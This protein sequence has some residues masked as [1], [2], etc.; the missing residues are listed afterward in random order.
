MNNDYIDD[1][2]KACFYESYTM[3]EKL[4]VNTRRLLY[5]KQERKSSLLLCIIQVLMF[6]LS[7][8]MLLAAF[9]LNSR[10]MF[11]MLGYAAFGNMASLVIIL[12]TNIKRGHRREN[13]I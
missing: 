6:T 7:I 10:V 9:Y 3:D 12:I 2:L 11:F 1:A 13:F 4:R 5:E 8:F